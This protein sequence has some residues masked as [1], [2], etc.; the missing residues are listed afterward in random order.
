MNW[1]FRMSLVNQMRQLSGESVLRRLLA[2]LA[3][4]ALVMVQVLPS[5]AAAS[6]AG[7]WVEI[8]SDSGVVVVQMDLG[9][10]PAPKQHTTCPDCINC[11]FCGAVGPAD[12]SADFVTVHFGFTPVEHDAIVTQFVM[13][14][15]AQFW[16]ANRGPPLVAETKNGTSALVLAKVSTLANGG[17][18]W[19]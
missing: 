15:P 6:G 17:A 14:N 12:V 5:I 10:D 2:V 13:A 1:V 3:V 19:N 7:E 11:A 4:L 9:G 18:P 16:R 8:C